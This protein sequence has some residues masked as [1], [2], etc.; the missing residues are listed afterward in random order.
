MI[1]IRFIILVLQPYTMLT[2]IAR[3]VR[4][5]AW[6]PQTLL[7]IC[8]RVRIC[9]LRIHQFYSSLYGQFCS[10]VRSQSVGNVLNL[11]CS[12]RAGYWQNN[13]IYLPYIGCTRCALASL[14]P[15][16][17]LD[18]PVGGS[19]GTRKCWRSPPLI[20]SIIF[21]SIIVIIFSMSSSYVQSTAS[22]ALSPVRQDNINELR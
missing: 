20:Y 3:L 16:L 4:Y 17:P 10:E 15:V 18:S 5:R 7:R 19:L 8:T 2:R 11:D 14:R 12:P 1:V 22:I 9:V 13:S 6:R 21:Y